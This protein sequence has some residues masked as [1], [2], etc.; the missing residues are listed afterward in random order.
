VAANKAEL[1]NF[2]FVQCIIFES[3]YYGGESATKK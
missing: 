1:E 2:I 3:N